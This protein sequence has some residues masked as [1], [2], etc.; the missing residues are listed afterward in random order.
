VLRGP[1]EAAEFIHDSGFRRVLFCG[2][3]GNGA[4]IFGVRSL[5]PD[6][7]TIVIRGDKLPDSTFSPDALN[8]LIRQYGVDSVVLERT[9]MPEPWDTLSARSLP[10]LTEKEVVTMTGSDRDGTLSIYRVNDPTRVPESSLK[11]PISVL[12]R[13]VDLRF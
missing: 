3:R 9:G 12:G 13:D 1:A 8:G 2:Y 11:A 4:F 5:D 10:F 6:L 7:N